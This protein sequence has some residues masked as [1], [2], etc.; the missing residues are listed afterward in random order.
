MAISEREKIRKILMELPELCFDY[1]SSIAEHTSELTRLSYVRDLKLF[2]NFLHKYVEGFE[3]HPKDYT[4]TEMKLLTP[5]NID[6]FMEYLSSYDVKLTS[7]NNKCTTIE[8]TNHHSG[9]K[10]KVCTI[11]AF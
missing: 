3:A 11:R 10:R 7:P 5:R 1:I 9:K 8:R 4:V 2:F 6:M